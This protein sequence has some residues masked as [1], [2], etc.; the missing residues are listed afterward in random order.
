MISSAADTTHAL[1]DRTRAFM[2]FI[3][4]LRLESI[5]LDGFFFFLCVT[6]EMTTYFCVNCNCGKNNLKKTKSLFIIQESH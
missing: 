1:P 4:H 3:C 5:T 6:S 2:D